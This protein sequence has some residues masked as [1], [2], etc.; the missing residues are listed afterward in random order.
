VATTIVAR[1][2]TTGSEAERILDQL[3]RVTGLHGEHVEG[4]RRYNLSETKDLIIAMASLKGHL[5]E[6]SA[7]WPTHVTIGVTD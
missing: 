1:K 3:E 6:I 7:T 2:L 4:G 5:D